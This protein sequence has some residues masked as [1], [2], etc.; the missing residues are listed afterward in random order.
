MTDKTA[1]SDVSFIFAITSDW[2]TG[3]NFQGT[4]TNNGSADITSWRL[5]FDYSGS[6]S[7]IWDARIV[8]RNGNHYII[9]SAGWNNSIPSKGSVSFGGGGSPGGNS[10]QPTNIVVTWK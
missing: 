3:Y 1:K 8:S 7:Q 2:G 5:E 6:I 10:S 9:E 4:L